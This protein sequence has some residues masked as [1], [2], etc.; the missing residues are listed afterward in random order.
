MVLTTLPL[1]SQSK[2]SIVKIYTNVVYTNV[3]CFISY[4]NIWKFSRVFLIFVHTIIGCG[5]HNSIRYP[6]L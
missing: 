5:A 2:K 6:C 4:Q 3:D 1:V